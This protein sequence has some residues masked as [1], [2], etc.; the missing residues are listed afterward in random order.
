MQF[1]IAAAVAVVAA[2]AEF[3]DRSLSLKIGDATLHPVLVVGRRL[4][5]SPEASKPD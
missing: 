2:L 1:I 5:R 4:G 3:T